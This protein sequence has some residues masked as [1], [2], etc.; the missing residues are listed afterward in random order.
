M[1]GTRVCG[2]LGDIL[3]DR[4][5]SLAVRRQIPRVLR[6]IPDQRSVDV[7]VSS[8]GA[9]DP[10]IR[11]AVLKALNRLRRSA[12]QLLFSAPAINQHILNE[13]TECFH[14]HTQRAAFGAAAPPR[15]VSALLT[16]TLENRVRQSMERLF[17]LLALRYSPDEVYNAYLAIE[18]GDPE[19]VTPAHDY[20]DS[21]LEREIKR[22]FMPLLDSPDRISTHARDLLHIQP[23]SL[24]T[25]V[26]E[27]LLS[28]DSW[29]AVC[30]IATAAELKLRGLAADIA[31][32]G[33]HAGKETV[34]VAR[35]AAA[36]LA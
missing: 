12:P 24:E 31:R 35:A 28:G 34:A 2:S 13:V 22:L 7:L 29:L 21:L 4:N 27:L 9:P 6:L 30:A 5:A 17:R 36:T 20:L 3:A 14:L 15:T 11:T 1:Y 8:L 16:K 10:A 32:A 23:K 19:R 26:R 33:E 18:S 25:A